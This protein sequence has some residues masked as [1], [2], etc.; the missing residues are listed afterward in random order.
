MLGHA[1]GVYLVGA[2]GLGVLFLGSA[3]WFRRDRSLS[4][5]RR[6]LKVSLVYLPG[7]LVLW[8]ADGALAWVL[9]AR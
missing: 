7:L 1:R 4:A 9:G 2:V 8:M 6:V 5:A 3:L